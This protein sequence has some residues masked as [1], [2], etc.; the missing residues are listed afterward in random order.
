M[1]SISVAPWL[2]AS[3]PSTAK[4][5]SPHK[6]GIY[7]FVYTQCVKNSATQKFANP[8]RQYIFAIGFNQ[9]VLPFVQKFHF[10]L[11]PRPNVPTKALIVV[12]TIVRNPLINGD[13]VITYRG[14]SSIL[15]TNVSFICTI[16][17]LVTL[18]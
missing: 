4:P 2:A 18:S 15:V 8:Q 7:R 5:H 17:F 13:Y 16:L 6:I 1:G 11:V 9:L 12:T 14:R 3:F 10:R